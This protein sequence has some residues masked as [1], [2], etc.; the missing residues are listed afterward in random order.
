MIGKGFKQG[1]SELFDE[2][3]KLVDIFTE[4]TRMK[5]L[6]TKYFTFQFKKIIYSL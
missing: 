4:K 5:M 6:E 1:L 2:S 3:M